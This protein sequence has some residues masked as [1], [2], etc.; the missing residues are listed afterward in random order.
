MVANVFVS[1]DHDDQKQV[2]FK[3]LKHNPNQVLEFED[4][5]LR[6]HILGRSGEPLRSPS[7]AR[8]K[9]VPDAIKQKFERA[10]KVVVLTG[11]ATY[12]SGWVDWEIETFHSMKEPISGDKAWKRLRGMT[13]KGSVHAIIPDALGNRSTKVMTWN[14][15]APDKWLDKDRDA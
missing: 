2:A 14:P 4:H 15:E 8:S 6:E 7:D 10:S 13:L 11:D 3:P 12:E 5:S 9:P 1:F